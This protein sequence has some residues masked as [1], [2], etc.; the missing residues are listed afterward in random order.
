MIQM[1]IIIKFINNFIL[2]NKISF[3]NILSILNSVLDNCFVMKRNA[4][5]NTDIENKGDISNIL[6]FENNNKIYKK[7]TR[8]SSYTN[9]KTDYEKKI[10]KDKIEIQ[11]TNGEVGYTSDYNQYLF[12]YYN[13]K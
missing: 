10:K 1:I 8:T 13:K 4:S 3:I 7:M 9:L 12:F 5:I 6:K 11:E 2:F